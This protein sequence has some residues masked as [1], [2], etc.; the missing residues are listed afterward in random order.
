MKF[1]LPAAN[2]AKIAEDSYQ[3]IK[4]FNE[5]QTGWAISDTRYYEIRYRH[6]GQDMLARVGEPD[7]LERQTVIAIFKPEATCIRP[8]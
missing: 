4:K 1:F 2:D 6:N 7:P 5:E 8:R 3:P